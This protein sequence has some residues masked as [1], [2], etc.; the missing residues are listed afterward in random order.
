M[1]MSSS[2]RRALRLSK[3]ILSS[4]VGVGGGV[5]TGMLVT[6]DAGED[7]IDVVVVVSSVVAAIV[8]VGVGVVRF[9]GMA[10]PL[11][12]FVLSVAVTFGSS[13]SASGSIRFWGFKSSLFL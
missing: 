1:V 7:S 2:K 13:T 10:L 12:L 4:S 6:D 11:V 5:Q 3:L 8:V 9:R